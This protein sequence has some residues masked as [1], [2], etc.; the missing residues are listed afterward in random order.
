MP[1]QDPPVHV[2][3]DPDGATNNANYVPSNVIV[4]GAGIAAGLISAGAAAAGT[5]AAI[6]AGTAFLQSA[7]TAGDVAVNFITAVPI[8]YVAV[9][10]LFGLLSVGLNAWNLVH[11]YR[12]K[13][14]L[15]KLSRDVCKNTAPVIDAFEKAAIAA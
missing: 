5:G 3:P 6:E 1:Q 8:Q 15:I 13:L 12:M 11:G 9:S 10:I 4:D 2:Y 7:A 14:R